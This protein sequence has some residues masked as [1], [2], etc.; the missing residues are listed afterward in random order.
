MR[1][2]LSTHPT[3]P[4]PSPPSA[5]A[6]APPVRLVPRHSVADSGPTG[7]RA[8]STRHNSPAALPTAAPSLP[9]FARPAA[10]TTPSD[11]LPL[12]TQL[13]AHSPAA[14]PALLPPRS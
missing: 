10:R 6:P 8:G 7:S 14:A 12:H 3:L 4:P 5:P 9:A 11:S 1:H 13:A 2:R